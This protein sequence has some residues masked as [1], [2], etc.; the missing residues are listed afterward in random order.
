MGRHWPLHFHGLFLVTSIHLRTFLKWLRENFVIHNFYK[1]SNK[2]GWKF[3]SK[4]MRW[5]NAHSYPLNVPVTWHVMN[6]MNTKVSNE[7]SWRKK[8][9]LNALIFSSHSSSLFYAIDT[10]VHTDDIISKAIRISFPFLIE[11]WV[12]FMN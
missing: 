6:G 2:I 3:L 7:M 9:R 12:C 8:Y 4:N 5:H 1:N 11:Y 10:H